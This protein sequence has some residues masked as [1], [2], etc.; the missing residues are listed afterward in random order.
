MNAR[1]MRYEAEIAYE[2]I[3]SGD[4]KGYT[5]REWSI[6]L[7]QAQENIVLEIC[8]NGLD[9]S[10]ENRRKIS[11][12]IKPLV[13]SGGL[14][15][16]GLHYSNSF[17]VNQFPEDYF[18]RASGRCDITTKNNIKVIPISRSFYDGNIDNPF[19]TPGKDR[20]WLIDENGVHIIITDGSVPIRYKLEYVSKPFPIIVEDLTSEEAIEEETQTTDCEL[21]PIVHREIVRE[22]AKLA[23]AYGKDQLGYQIQSV[24]QQK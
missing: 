1:E 9:E 15:S 6:L 22:A 4:A 16:Q 7:T 3:A 11:K 14:L 19:K 20:F 2:S 23:Y 21:D 17:V 10:E 12:L 5:D 8:K 24:E 18:Y 13:I